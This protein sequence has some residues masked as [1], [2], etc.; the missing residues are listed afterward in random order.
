MPK[1]TGNQGDGRAE[2]GLPGDEEER[3][4]GEGAGHHQVAGIA[5]AAAVLAEEH[6][7]HQRQRDA[8]ELRRLQVERPDVDPAGGVELR[9]PLEEHVDEER[10]SGR[11]RGGASSRPA[12]GSRW[13]GRRAARSC[14]GRWRRSGCRTAARDARLGQ[15]HVG[16]AVDHRHADAGDDQDGARAAASRRGRTGGVRTCATSLRT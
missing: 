16:G 3:H 8:A 15:V 11:R 2:I 5:R 14:R 9:R 13:P 4:G 6:R 10:R 7:Q 12:C 1:Q